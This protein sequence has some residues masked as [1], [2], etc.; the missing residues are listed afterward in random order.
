MLLLYQSQET[1]SIINR[2]QLGG[3]CLALNT[4]PQGGLQGCGTF[5]GGWAYASPITCVQLNLNLIHVEKELPFF[6]N[7][8]FLFSP[9]Y[10]LS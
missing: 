7:I 3:M 6:V 8:L 9:L 1:C 4:F 2:G 5:S 10:L